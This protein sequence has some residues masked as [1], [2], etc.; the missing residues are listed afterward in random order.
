MVRGMSTRVNAV[1]VSPIVLMGMMSVGAVVE[2]RWMRAIAIRMIVQRTSTLFEHP[3]MDY[4]VISSVSDSGIMVGRMIAI[5]SRMIMCQNGVG[6]RVGTCIKTRIWRRI[7]QG[8][9]SVSVSLSRN[10]S[11]RSHI[12]G[13]MTVTGVR[14]VMT[15]LAVRGVLVIRS[16][17]C[18]DIGHTRSSAHRSTTHDCRE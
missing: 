7:A 4:F 16:L 14:C 17:T 9:I 6:V 11:A 1:V 10:F 3:R 18:C 2:V 13:V 12:L 5:V 8:F 15:M